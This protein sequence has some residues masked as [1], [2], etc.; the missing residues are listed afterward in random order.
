MT[1]RP[2]IFQGAMV[3][4]LLAGT[5]TQTR[6]PIVSRRK[7]A[8]C[9]VIYDREGMGPW[10]YYSEDGERGFYFDRA[11]YDVQETIP[12]PYGQPGDRLWVRET[13]YCDHCFYPDGTPDSG[14][15]REV[16]GKRVP[17]PL[18]EKRDDMLESMYYRADGEPEFEAPEG[19]IPWRP[20]IHMPRWVSRILLEVTEVH[21]EP[22]QEISVADCIAE[23]I[24]LGGPE[25]PDGIERKEYRA[26]WESINGAGSWDENPWVWVVQFRRIEP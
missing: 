3:R 7:A 25:N 22:L 19:P 24:P 8:P 17:I 14:Q 26:L 21:V 16:D 1:E 20:G 9:F 18:D 15:W 2:I 10:P 11:G 4:A 5:K 6:R 23:G 13:F 12:C